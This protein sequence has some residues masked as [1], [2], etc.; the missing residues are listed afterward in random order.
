[1]S[2]APTILWPRFPCLWQKNT[3]AQR[4][5]ATTAVIFGSRGW[6]FYTGLTVGVYVYL[7]NTFSAATITRATGSQKDVKMNRDG[8]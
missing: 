3:S 1:L 2:T 5:P 7:N 6:P 4:P 8:G